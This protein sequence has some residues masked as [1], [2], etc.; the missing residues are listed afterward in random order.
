MKTQEEKEQQLRDAA[1]EAK[2]KYDKD[3]MDWLSS[4]D[5]GN[6]NFFIEQLI[7]FAKSE[8]ARQY[9]EPDN[10]V[11]LEKTITDIIHDEI[12][13][14]FNGFI[15]GAKSAARRICSHLQPSAKESDAVEFLIWINENYYRSKLKKGLF[16]KKDE[17]DNFASIVYTENLLYQEF[18]K[19][20]TKN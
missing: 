1:K 12:E 16:I 20:K 5:Y 6:N 2:L 7:D 17:V 14:D 8:A 4:T 10:N 11:D 18:L 15:K 19:S 13:A 3:V 9:H